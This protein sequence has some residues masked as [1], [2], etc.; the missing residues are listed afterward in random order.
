M[1]IWVSIYLISVSSIQQETYH[2]VRLEL[3]ASG[4]WPAA[5]DCV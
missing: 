2:R 1:G 3:A 4:V 5:I